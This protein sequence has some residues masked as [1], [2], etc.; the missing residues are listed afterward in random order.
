[1]SNPVS[2]WKYVKPVSKA[3]LGCGVVFDMHH[4]ALRCRPCARQTALAQMRALGKTRYYADVGAS[5]RQRHDWVARNQIQNLLCSA[6]CRAK[7]TGVEFSITPADINIP[8][9]CPYLGIKLNTMQGFD[10]DAAPSID[11]IDNSFGYVPGNVEVIS[12]RANRAKNNLL[13]HEAVMMAKGF[14]ERFA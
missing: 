5:R 7:K 4:N 14:L 11:R 12:H 6:R 8:V 13:P 2:N 9:V 10:Q 3:C 1:M